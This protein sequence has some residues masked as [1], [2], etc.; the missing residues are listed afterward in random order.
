MQDFL[1]HLQSLFHLFTD[2][3]NPNQTKP[4]PQNP[5]ETKPKRKKKAKP[6]GN[7]RS[8]NNHRI[9]LKP[10]ISLKSI[11]VETSPSRPSHTL[12][13]SMLGFRQ[14]PL[15]CVCHIV[16]SLPRWLLS[17]DV[18]LQLLPLIPSFP[19]AGRSWGPSREQVMQAST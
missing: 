18:P 6:T 12:L 3:K 8:Y 2:K 14:T 5:K 7:W 10:Q 1:P 17:W 9:S 16:A 15:Y 11:L 19:A 13:A 4:K